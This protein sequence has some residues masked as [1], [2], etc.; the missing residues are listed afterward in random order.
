MKKIHQNIIYIFLLLFVYSNS[1]NAQYIVEWA[2]GFGGDGSDVA[3]CVIETSDGN[4]LFAGEMNKNQK[5][6]W[7]LKSDFS[8][9]KIWGKIYD[10]NFA[11]GAYSVIPT[12]DNNYIIAGYIVR[13][14]NDK[15]SDALIMKVD[16]RG[17]Q[18]WRK[19][20]GGPF[21]DAFK[22]IVEGPDGSLYAAGYTEN[23]LDGERIFWLVKLDS[24]GDFIAENGFGDTQEDVANSIIIT[25]DS[26]VVL[27][28]YGIYE[29]N[30]I[31][32]V[33]SFD[34]DCQFKWESDFDNMKFS[35]IAGIIESEDNELVMVGTVKND[36]LRDFDTFFLKY[37][38]TGDSISSKSVGFS[39]YWE[40]ATAIAKTYDGN[41]IV[42]AF[43][44]GD[45]AINSNFLIYKISPEFKIVWETEFKKYSLDYS[46]DICELSDNGFVIAGSTY[47]LE[48]GI[49]YAAMKFK[50]LN[51]TTVH[52]LSP[53]MDEL[54]VESNVL[55]LEACISGYDIPQKVDVIVNGFVQIHDAFSNL[56]VSTNICKYPFYSEVF[57]DDGYNEI[58]IY[59]IDKRGFTAYDKLRVHFVPPQKIN[60]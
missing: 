46:Y 35:E 15:Y 48:K 56:T 24:K 38:L 19:T 42:S 58:E 26:S 13:R 14:K 5:H 37:S 55:P 21:N 36:N 9:N 8:G 23:E 51:K 11:S 43:R 47:Q 52:F 18:I 50:D 27:A 31:M 4:I 1:L 10:N 29:S 54:A 33:I 40:E 7:L 34:L 45:G 6:I 17:R 49:D 2:Q 53:A 22:D 28:G 12:S 20:Y 25:S 57:L 41:F 3:K 16:T 44:K 32:R 30:K 60:W 59:V 39:N